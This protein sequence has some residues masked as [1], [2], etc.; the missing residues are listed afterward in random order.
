MTEGQPT[1]SKS[2]GE[3]VKDAFKKVG[4]ALDAGVSNIFKELGQNI[5]A[6]CPN[7][8][9]LILAPPNEFVQCPLCSHQFQSPT[10]STRTGEVGSAVGKDIKEA[11]ST[12]G[13]SGPKP[14]ETPRTS[15]A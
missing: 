1:T 13:P 4:H 6:N 10:V 15:G 12:H 9:Q 11:W 5:R 3:T 7:C 14:P 2:A 8:K